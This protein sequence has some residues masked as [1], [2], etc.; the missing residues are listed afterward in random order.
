MLGSSI[1]QV[2]LSGQ[3]APKKPQG[4]AQSPE[5]GEASFSSIPIFTYA[6][7]DGGLR[8]ASRNGS[9]FSPL[10]Q[11]LCKQHCQF[12]SHGHDRS[13]FGILSAVRGQLQ[14]PAA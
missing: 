4:R 1:Q 5:L 13:F 12:A 10:T 8:F 3:W 6:A 7:T 14:T 2:L 11:S 9:Y